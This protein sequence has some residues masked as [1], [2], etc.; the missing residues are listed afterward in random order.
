MPSMEKTKKKSAKGG[1]SA[2]S[3]AAKDRAR[4]KPD[5]ETARRKRQAII[6]CLLLASVT[7]AVYFRVSGNSFVE[8]D[9]PDYVS[10]NA[11]VQAGLS[12]QTVSWAFTATEAANWHPLTW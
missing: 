7:F 4:A 2:T 11:Q 9:D 8:Y 6:L 3:P 12:W 5:P 10:R 1:R